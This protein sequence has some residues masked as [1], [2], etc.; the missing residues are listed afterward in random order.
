MSLNSYAWFLATSA[1]PKSRQPRP[2]GTISA[3]STRPLHPAMGTSGTHLGVARY[4]SDD[5]EGAKKALEKSCMLRG[6]ANA[7]DWFVLAMAYWHLGDK[8][9]ALR[10]F[11]RAVGLDLQANQPRRRSWSGSSRRSHL[12]VCQRKGREF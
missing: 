6:W 2:G 1:D 10:Q 8:D 12:S 3:R 11:K 4:R 5:W 9:L 7:A